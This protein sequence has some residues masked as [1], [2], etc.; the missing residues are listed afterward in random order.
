MLDGIQ[1]SL[2]WVCDLEVSRERVEPVVAS[3]AAKDTTRKQYLQMA[4]TSPNGS[5]E[6]IFGKI[7]PVCVVLPH[8]PGE[9]FRA[10]FSQF[11]SRSFP[12][13][14]GSF[15]LFAADFQSILVSFSQTQFKQAIQD[16][17]ARISYRQGRWG[18]TTPNYPN[19]I[20]FANLK[21]NTF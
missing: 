3:P 1:H 20:F 16:K 13:Y 5:L 11:F 19:S 15:S 18:E 2:F 12:H 9:I 14:F 8:L 6:A 21:L 7:S 17:N 4:A 10:I